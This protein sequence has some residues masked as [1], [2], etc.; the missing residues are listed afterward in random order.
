MPFAIK[1]CCSSIGIML[2]IL[3][4]C[5]NGVPARL[6]DVASVPFLLVLFFWM[7][8]YV[9]LPWSIAQ[10]SCPVYLIHGILAYLISAVF[11][12]LGY[13]SGQ[14]T[15]ICGVISFIVA[16]AASMLATVLIRKILPKFAH[17]AFGGR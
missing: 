4:C 6:L 8:Q 15:F 9:K 10:M 1:L 3:L 11:G 17:A 2:L 7:T 16:V 14:K 12:M 13:G 5:C